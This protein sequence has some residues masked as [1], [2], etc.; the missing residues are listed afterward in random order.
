MTYEGC[1]KARSRLLQRLEGVY[2]LAHPFW[3]RSERALLLYWQAMHMDGSMTPMESWP[4]NHMDVTACICWSV[5]R[6]TAGNSRM[7][8]LGRCGTCTC[9]LAGS[10]V[11]PR[12]SRLRASM[13]AGK[14]TIDYFQLIATSRPCL[15]PGC[16]YEAGRSAHPDRR[17]SLFGLLDTLLTALAARL[18]CLL[19]L[20]ACCASGSSNAEQQTPK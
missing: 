13:P 15:S 2:P 10:P 14:P 18:I 12:P 20:K 3:L 4:S 8:P 17:D 6:P 9:R 1:Q 19:R 11:V 7:T 5:G 16:H